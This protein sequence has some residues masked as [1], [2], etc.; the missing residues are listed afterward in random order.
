MRVGVIVRR[1]ALVAAVAASLP[2]SAAR[3]QAV[4][5]DVAMSPART[6]SEQGGAALYRNACAGCHM[7]DG[8]GAVGAARYP[9]LAGDENLAAAGYPL[10]VVLNGSRSM[11]AVGRMM[12]DAQ[13]ADVVNYVRSNFGN[14][15][16]DAL[17]ASDAHDA[18]R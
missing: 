11:P 3:A 9:A 1:V 16:S 12:S 14:G 4:S 6:F 2:S 8:R 17:T 5:A 10:S 13:V 18:R 15:F 7:P